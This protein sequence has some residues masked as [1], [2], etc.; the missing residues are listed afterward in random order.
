LTRSA[1]LP[2]IVTALALVTGCA[3]QGMPPGGPI[4]K[5]PPQL[6]AVTPDSG[7]LHVGAKQTVIFRFDE[8][9]N[10]R[11]RAGGSLDQGVVVSPSEGVISVDWHR[12]YITIRSRKGWRPDVAYTVTILPGLQDLSG[13]GTRK[14]LQTVFSTGTVI[15][16]AEVS[17][18]AFD[19]VTQTVA[20]GARIEAMI[21][22]DTALKFTAIADSTGRFV[23]TTLPPG[24]LHLRAYVD[25]NRNHVLDPR[26]LWDSSSVA[27]T[28]TASREFYVFAHDTIGPSIS[29]VTAVDSVTLRV[30]FDRPLLPG[31]P[32]AASQFSLKLRDTTKTDSVP[33]AVSTVLSAVQYDSVTTRHKIFA[34]D[35]AMRADTSAAGRK[36][37][38]RK[39]SLD[40]AAAL[41]SA[42]RAQIASVKA[43][44]DSVK[45]VVLPKPSRAA[46]LSEFILT[47][48]EPLPYDMFGTLS[49]TDA[50]GLTGH[51]HKPAR[52]KQVVLRKPPAP[53]DST[54]AAAKKPPAKDSTA[55]PVK[56]P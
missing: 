56:K 34:R 13:N 12:T 44:R 17:G 49:V 11:T 52:V 51:V 25:A 55:A 28:D 36:A 2:F 33:V 32:L 5:T 48:A 10:E 3:S 53:K 22:T 37:V 40:R 1:R 54:A 35:S 30:R 4:D 19:W 6:I 39:D 50:T 26:E 46:P 20:S 45:P 21:G 47:L 29:D 8:V 42:S 41:D 15:P 27:L 7:T 23:M 14:A 31:A 43:G 16:T 9:V 24:A 38:A 18:V